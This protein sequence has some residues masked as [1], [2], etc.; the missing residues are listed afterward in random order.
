MGSSDHSSFL[1]LCFTV[2]LTHNMCD[3][4]RTQPAPMNTCCGRLNWQSHTYANPESRRQGPWSWSI[5]QHRRGGTQECGH[6][7]T[8]HI[9]LS[10]ACL[11]VPVHNTQPPDVCAEDDT[12]LGRLPGR[13]LKKNPSSI[14]EYLLPPA[15]LFYDV[16]EH[17]L[18]PVEQTERRN[19]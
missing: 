5:I 13:K 16:P 9:N 12:R 1:S 3:R 8:A 18:R 17:H 6:G 10:S 11:A 4:A 19:D 15:F 14:K 7:M 2:T